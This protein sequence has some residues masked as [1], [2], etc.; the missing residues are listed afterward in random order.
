MKIGE[1]LKSARRRLVT[2][3]PDDTLSA[4]AKAL[5]AHGIGALP[6]CKIG[7]GGGGNAA[8]IGLGLG[9]I[10]GLI[11]SGAAQQDSEDYDDDDAPRY[12]RRHCRYGSWVDHRGVRH[13]RE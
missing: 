12:H 5:H 4:V 9:I 10:G 11:E 8:A 6:V 3:M 2:C 13:C 7:G 1:F